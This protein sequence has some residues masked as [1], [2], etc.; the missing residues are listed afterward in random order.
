M[1]SE[2]PRVMRLKDRGAFPHPCY[3]PLEYAGEVH[4]EYLR[5]FGK[6]PKRSL[7]VGMN[8]GPWGM[9]QTGV[10]FADPEI[11]GEWMGLRNVPIT[12]P[13][14]QFEKRPIRGWESGR[15]EGSGQRLFGFFR[16]R[17]GSL[18][19]FF[20]ENF[21]IN[22]CPVIMFTDAGKNLT[23]AD[24]PRA[25]REKIFRECDPY[26]AYLIEFYRPAVLVGIG[27]FAFERIVAATATI[28]F[29]CSTDWIPHP[30]PA[31]P[32]ATRD[33]GRYWKKLVGEKLEQ[34]GVL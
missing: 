33:G 32:I 28:N 31:S 18:E 19:N 9:G 22:Y 6:R 8:P 17:F 20:E 26:L 7:F 15:K 12:I 24:L 13:Q 23:P 3:F 1:K 10:P 21:V 4:R 27:K 25:K 2:S 16:E 34:L 30:S 11:A 5:R 29:E 14:Q